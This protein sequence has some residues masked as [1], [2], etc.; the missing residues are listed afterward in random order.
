MQLGKIYTVH[1]LAYVHEAQ[2][3][4]KSDTPVIK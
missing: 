1:L 3:V 4:C 2:P